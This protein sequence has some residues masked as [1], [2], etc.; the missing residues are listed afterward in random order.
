MLGTN[1]YGLDNT[2]VNEGAFTIL[3]VLRA[4]TDD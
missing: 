2:L 3:N 1:G 4:H